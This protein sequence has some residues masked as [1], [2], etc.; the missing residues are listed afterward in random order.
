[1]RIARQPYAVQTHDFRELRQRMD[2]LVTFATTD[3]SS[4]TAGDWAQ[5]NEDLADC[6]RH[7]GDGWCHRDRRQRQHLIVEERPGQRFPHTRS[8][9]TLQREVRQVFE[10]HV[11]G[12]NVGRP[13]ALH[14]QYEELRAQKQIELFVRGDLRSLVLYALFHD[15]LAYPYKPI[16]RCLECQRIFYSYRKQQFCTDACGIKQRNDQRPRTADLHRTE[17]DDPRESDDG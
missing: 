3:W 11:D 13:I 8:V 2:F 1:M 10:D 17:K 4:N 15:L 9:K 14:L 12:V 5:L 7:G 6:V 16:K